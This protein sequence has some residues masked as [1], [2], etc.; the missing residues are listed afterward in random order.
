MKNVIK[1]ICLYFTFTGAMNA[2]HFSYEPSFISNDMIWN[3]AS[4]AERDYLEY[5]VFYRQQ[6]SGFRDAPKTIMAH[7]EYPFLYNNMSIGGYF[8]GDKAGVIDYFKAGLN[9]AYK[10]KIGIKRHDQLSIG[11]SANISQFSLATNRIISNNPEDPTIFML[12]G[13]SLKPDADLGILYISDSR[14]K[15]DRSYWYFGMSANS[16]VHGIDLFR[17]TD[18]SMGINASFHGNAMLGISQVI[19]PGRLNSHVWYSYTNNHS[20]RVGGSLGIEFQEAFSVGFLGASDGSAGIKL[21]TNI[22]GDFMGDGFLKVEVS[23]LSNMSISSLGK[24]PTFEFYM[25]YSFRTE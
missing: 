14:V 16:L 12:E 10:V 24:N 5:G 15:R 9:Y 1:I 23:G 20:Y 3:P 2:Q 6:W 7:A 22:N 17:Q 19:P 8:Y 11:L 21:G 18:S 25:A 4:T 13:T